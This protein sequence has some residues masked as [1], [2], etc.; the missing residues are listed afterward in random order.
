MKSRW[1]K[2]SFYAGCMGNLANLYIATGQYDRAEPLCLEAKSILE[3][4]YGT[5]HPEYVFSLQSLANLYERQLRFSEADSLL[6]LVFTANISRISKATTFLSEQELT[7]YIHLFESDGND[8][9]ANG[10]T[11]YI[12]QHERG[13][14]VGL[15]YDHTLYHKGFLLLNVRRLTALA[16]STPASTGL[17]EKLKS[18]RKALAIEYAKPREQQRNTEQLEEQANAVEKSLLK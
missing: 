4:Q 17:F 12:G 1:V 18:Q 13:K 16:T 2:P 10:Y 11:R 6:Q 7:N 3:Q 14:L 8:L 5:E 15:A 9:Y